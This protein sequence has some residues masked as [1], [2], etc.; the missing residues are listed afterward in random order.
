MCE[1]FI[2]HGVLFI[3]YGVLMFVFFF[4]VA[5][6]ES[7]HVERDKVQVNYQIRHAI[8]YIAKSEQ[9]IYFSNILFFLI[10]FNFI[11]TSSNFSKIIRYFFIPILTSSSSNRHPHSDFLIYNVLIVH[12]TFDKVLIFILT[13]KCIFLHRNHLLTTKSLIYHIIS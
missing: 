12:L 9:N 8:D 11:S 6:L 2:K 5:N 13:S 3:R 4:S 1:S 10:S 7:I